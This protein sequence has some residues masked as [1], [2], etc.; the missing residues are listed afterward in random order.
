MSQ[1]SSQRVAALRAWWNAL[2]PEREIFLRSGGQVKFIRI[3]RRAQLLT[4]G[5]VAAALVG[6]GGITATMASDGM[7]LAQ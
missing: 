4:L 7:A 6:C 5:S 1:H 3:S 2:C